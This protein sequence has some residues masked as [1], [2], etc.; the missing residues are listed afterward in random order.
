V[1]HHSRLG[2]CDVTECQASIY[3]SYCIVAV[4]PIFNNSENH[5]ATQIG[6][7]ALKILP[8]YFFQKKE[9]LAV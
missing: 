2:A 7:G 9:S 6:G 5:C 8:A 4:S 1:S 3:D